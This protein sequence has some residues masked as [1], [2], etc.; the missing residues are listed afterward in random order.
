M[1]P[2]LLY[3]K[4]KTH[5]F[6][7]HGSLRVSR[8][9]FL[10]S[11][12]NLLSLSGRCGIVRSAKSRYVIY[13]LCLIN[14]SCYVLDPYRNNNTCCIVYSSCPYIYYGYHIDQILRIVEKIPTVAC[15]Y[16]I[17]H[18]TASKQMSIYTVM[19]KCNAQ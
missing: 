9:C 13:F 3:S 11:S 10:I 14:P 16:Q 18:I 1:S 15:P 12:Q 8:N 2:K 4:N 17:I 7:Q 6:H 5:A 19:K